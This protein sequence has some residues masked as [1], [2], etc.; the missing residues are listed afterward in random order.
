MS[1]ECAVSRTCICICKALDEKMTPHPTLGI[2]YRTRLRKT[3]LI[4]VK[5]QWESNSISTRNQASRTRALNARSVTKVY[6]N[7]VKWQDSCG[8]PPPLPPIVLHSLSPLLSTTLPARAGPRMSCYVH[9]CMIVISSIPLLAESNSP[10][11]K[12]VRRLRGCVLI[13]VLC[14]SVAPQVGD[15]D[16]S[17]RWSH[18]RNRSI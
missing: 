12:H 3:R 17:S 5:C 10:P 13:D 2:C 8:Y 1:S 15:H 7:C 11:H 14:C 4:L 18:L 6:K 9:R 16:E